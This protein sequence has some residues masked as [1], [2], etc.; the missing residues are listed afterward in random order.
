MTGIFGR[1]SV[2]GNLGEYRF[3]DVGPRG[4]SDPRGQHMPTISNASKMQ[5]RR[6]QERGHAD[7]GWLRT[8]HTFSFANYYDPRFMGFRSLRVIN[9]DSVQPGQGFG[10]HGHENME[11]LTYVLDGALEHKDSM[12]N[13]SIIRPGEVQRMSAG[14]GVTHSEFNASKTE[15]VHFLQIWILPNQVGIAPSYEQKSFELDSSSDTWTL[16]ASNDGRN[17]SVTIHQDATMLVGR[18][19]ESHR[20]T[21]SPPPKRNVF[22]HVARG[23][24]RVGNDR[25]RAGDALWSGDPS[26]IGVEAIESSEVLLFDLA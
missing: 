11:I 21:Y 14:T 9:E 13:G 25:L 3:D 23:A 12:G 20:L 22:V 7:H 17:D 16:L 2:L 1:F 26:P 10:T 18:I 19:G 24:V 15:L 4:S 8:Y 6:A 5:I